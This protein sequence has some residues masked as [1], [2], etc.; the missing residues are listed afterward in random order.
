MDFLANWIVF[1]PRKLTFVEKKTHTYERSS[2]IHNNRKIANCG[3]QIANTGSVLGIW[4]RKWT[5]QV[6]NISNRVLEGANQGLSSGLWRDPF[7]W[8][9]IVCSGREAWTVG[10]SQTVGDSYG[11]VSFGQWKF[12]YRPFRRLMWWSRFVPQNFVYSCICL[13]ALPNKTSTLRGLNLRNTLS[14]SL[15]ARSSRSRCW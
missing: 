12:I 1:V 14:C 6:N 8:H 10:W 7:G 2:I 15:E 11:K 13:L 9:S 4:K 3:C 5:L